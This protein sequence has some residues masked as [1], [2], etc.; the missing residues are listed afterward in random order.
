MVLKHT[1]CETSK[2]KVD[3]TCRSFKMY[4]L[5]G[6]DQIVVKPIDSASAWFTILP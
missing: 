6:G 2:T 4:L 1:R 5:A 3:D